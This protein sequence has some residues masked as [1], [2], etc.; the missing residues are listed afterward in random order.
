MR[1]RGT[2]RA[3]Q[4]IT[5]DVGGTLMEPWPSVGHVYVKVA[6]RHGV[7][8]LQAEQLTERFASAWKARK[9]FN[10]S[11]TDWAEIV[12]ATFH[13]QNPLPVRLFLASFI[14][15]LPN[16]SPG[17]FSRMFCLRWTAWHLKA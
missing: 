2:D 5:F 4:A 8:G 10:Y 13:A 11:R 12:D 6:E 16:L 9:D 14:T 1:A 17:A 7:R 3:I 15:I